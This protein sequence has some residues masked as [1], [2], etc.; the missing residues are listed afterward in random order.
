MCVERLGDEIIGA[1]LQSAQLGALVGGENDD[2]DAAERLNAAHDLHDLKAVH[3]RHHQVQQDD[4]KLILMLTDQSESLFSVFGIE[5]VVIILQN[6]A[7]RVAVDFLIVHHQ[8]QR[9][10]PQLF[11]LG[12]ASSFRPAPARIQCV[13]VAYSRSASI[14]LTRCAFIPD[15]M[16]R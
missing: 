10:V 13:R 2:R 8:H 1:H 7:Q 14:G 4:R 9:S 5:N 15:S 16:E 3:H 12:H 11:R 6:D